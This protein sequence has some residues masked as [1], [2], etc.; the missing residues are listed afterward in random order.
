MH[1]FI[2][3]SVTQKNTLAY[4][5]NVR[6]GYI[7]KRR[8]NMCNC[9]ENIPFCHRR[10]PCNHFCNQPPCRQRNLFLLAAYPVNAVTAQNYG[11]STVSIEAEPTTVPYV[12]QYQ[13]TP[14]AGINVANNLTPYANLYLVNE[15]C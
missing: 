10:Q 6:S 5:N 14:R 9:L 2:N 15:L 11:P 12:Y 4:N 7:F 8:L 3:H 13:G 1:L